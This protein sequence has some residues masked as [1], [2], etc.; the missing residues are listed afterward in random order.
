MARLLQLDLGRVLV[1]AVAIAL[2]ACNQASDREVEKSLFRVLTIK[3]LAYGSAVGWGTAFKV[4][5]PDTVVTNNHVVQDATTILLVY[6]SEGKFVESEARVHYAD[7]A[8]DLAVLKAV[9][10]LPG[11]P[12]PVAQYTP[13]SG[14]EAWALGFPHAADAV[15][16]GIR[17]I[18]D[19]LE[20]L[21]RDTSMSQPTRTFG[22][23]SGERPMN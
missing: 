22:T 2:S 8:T 16:G 1:C 12:L 21:S 14:S 3:Q 9:R 18:E 15:F 7:K 17:S 5:E 4:S 10:P 13:S 23:V 19:F 6:W 11:L 20:K